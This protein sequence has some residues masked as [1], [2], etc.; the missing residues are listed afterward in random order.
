MYERLAKSQPV[1]RMGKQEEV[2]TL[3]LFLCSDEASF[4]PGWIIQLDGRFS[5]CAADYEPESE[6]KSVLVTGAPRESRRRDRARHRGGRSDSRFPGSD[7]KRRRNCTDFAQH[8][9]RRSM[10][11]SRRDQPRRKLPTRPSTDTKTIWPARCSCE[12][13]RRQRQRKPGARYH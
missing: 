8:S 10:F 4:V 1:R 9:L 13:R 5:T 3:A 2:A 11:V 12:Q 7:V 6:G